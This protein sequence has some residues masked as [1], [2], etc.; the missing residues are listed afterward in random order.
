MAKS[1]EES[2]I[3]LDFVKEYGRLWPRAVF[4]CVTSEGGRRK[5]YLAKELEILHQPGVYILYRD[6]LPFYIGKSDDWIWHRLHVHARRF[7]G[8]YTYFWNYFS[9]FAIPEKSVRTLV[10]SI[11]IAAI[12]TAA[13]SSN[14][15]LNRK[16]VPP[17]VGKMMKQLRDFPYDSES[18]E[19]ADD[20]D[21]IED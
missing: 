3:S 11:L 15:K 9:F 5:T 10:E 16:R 7:G 13:N 8:P 20:Y 2:I 6:D 12:P 14:P 17:A 1:I 18:I 21:G 19:E 4:D